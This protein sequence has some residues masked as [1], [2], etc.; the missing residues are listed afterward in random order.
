LQ[1]ARGS[2]LEIQ[3]GRKVI[4]PSNNLEAA[5]PSK[6]LLTFPENLEEQVSKVY[7]KPSGDE[8]F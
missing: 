1:V 6:D 7:K 3:T 5:P 8:L 2:H 4:S